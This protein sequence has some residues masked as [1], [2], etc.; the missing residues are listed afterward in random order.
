M[1]WA[2]VVMVVIVLQIVRTLFRSGLA[3]GEVFFFVLGF[4]MFVMFDG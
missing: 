3:F 1:P 4:A 2:V